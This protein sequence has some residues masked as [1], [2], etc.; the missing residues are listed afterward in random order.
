MNEIPMDPLAVSPKVLQAKLSFAFDLFG[1]ARR[2]FAGN[3]LE[4]THSCVVIVSARIDHDVLVIVVRQ[5][6]IFRVTTKSELQDA[7]AGK[8]KVITQ[9]FHVRSNDAEVFG[10]DRQLAERFTN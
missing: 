10:D 9:L 7:H 1:R 2:A 6:D 8:S 4:P 3:A 5:I